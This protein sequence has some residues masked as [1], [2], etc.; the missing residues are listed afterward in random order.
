MVGVH[1]AAH[2]FPEG[3]AAAPACFSINPACCVIDTEVATFV[4]DVLH[5]QPENAMTE[6]AE[7]DFAVQVIVALRRIL[8]TP[9]PLHEVVVEPVAAWSEGAWIYFVYRTERSPLTFGWPRTRVD[10][11]S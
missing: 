4:D 10:R 8:A 11:A 1:N 7:H 5:D 2:P 6:S 9:G 3:N